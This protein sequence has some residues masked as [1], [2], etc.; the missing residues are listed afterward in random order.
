M[1]LL[2]NR[3]DSMERGIVTDARCLIYTE[4]TE[5]W[6]IPGLTRHLVLSFGEG[7]IPYDGLSS[8]SRVTDSRKDWNDEAVL[9]LGP[10]GATWSALCPHLSQSG[11]RHRILRRRLRQSS[12]PEDA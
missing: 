9:E 5:I 10:A 7:T 1:W 12:R 2:V 4:C 11:L 6:D 8:Q 3:D